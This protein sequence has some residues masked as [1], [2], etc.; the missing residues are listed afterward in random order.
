[1]TCA[2]E[3]AK[4]KSANHKNLAIRQNFDPSKYTHYT[5]T[6][7]LQLQGI[8]LTSS[9]LQY[10][11]QVTIIIKSVSHYSTISMTTQYTLTWWTE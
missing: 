8:K 11:A 10:L 7:Q 6:I 4:L 9:L 1:M 2:Y 3:F 5:V